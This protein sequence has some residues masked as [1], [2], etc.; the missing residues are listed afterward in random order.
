MKI[1]QEQ[2]EHIRQQ[3][4]H[5]KLILQ[6]IQMNNLMLGPSDPTISGHHKGDH[7]TNDNAE[8]D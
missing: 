6:H 5:M 4:E 1:H 7:I 8:E 3:D 2:S